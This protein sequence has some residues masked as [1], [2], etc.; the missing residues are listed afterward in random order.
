MNMKPEQEIHVFVIG[1]GPCSGKTT[2][3]AVISERLNSLPNT[4]VLIIP[5]VAT[6]LISAGIPPTEALFQKY[7]LEFGISM[8]NFFL[9]R[10]SEF[11]EQRIIVLCDRGLLDG[12]AYDKKT[13]LASLTEMGLTIPALRDSRYNAIFHLVTAAEGA[14]EYY[15]LENNKARYETAE[16]ARTRDRALQNAYLGHSHVRVIDNSTDF[17][18]KIDRLV[19]EIYASL[20]IPI[21]IEIEKKYLVDPRCTITDIAV[22]YQAVN[23]IQHFLLGAPGETERVRK[24]EQDGIATFYHT[25]KRRIKNGV[26]Q[27][28]ERM[29]TREEYL[30]L[31]ERQDPSKH[32]IRKQRACFLYKNQ[33][34]ELD[35]FEEPNKGLVLLE[36]ELTEE[37]QEI[38]LPNFIPI[39]R[40]VTGEKK[41]G[42][43]NLA[44]KKK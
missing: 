15:T 42:N 32:A 20:G 34:F 31:R 39:V 14:E 6:L 8:E 2:G 44:S 38:S 35:F 25:I 33:Y 23:I 11:S 43:V 12:I 9:K 17:E 37:Q 21:P 22:P 29:I 30:D 4:K 24:R 40:E 28:L 10:A 13:F 5:E 3:L 27:E 19:K 41:Y 26:N 7:V 16:E 1:G 36:I 18:K